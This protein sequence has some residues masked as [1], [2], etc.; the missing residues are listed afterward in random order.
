MIGLLAAATAAAGLAASLPA[1][2]EPLPRE[3]IFARARL[4]GWRVEART[5]VEEV[6]G[7]PTIGGVH[8]E[9]ARSGLKLVTWREGGLTIEIGY[10]GEDPELDIERGDIHRIALDERV[11]EFR[12]LRLHG[13]QDG[14]SNVRY[15]PFP[16][17]CAGM[18][19]HQIIVYGC[20]A[21]VVYAW[22]EGI[23]RRP[24]QPWLGTG[25]LADEL[26]RARVLRIGFRQ[27][28][29]DDGAARPLLWAE[30]P[31]TGLDRAIGWCRSA[32]E[33]EAA[34]RFHGGLEEE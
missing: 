21:D 2:R 33:S 12:H 30:V 4:A 15:P 20:G 32:F 8:C 26:L 6:A 34:R 5:D 1:P 29:R 16:D 24:G 18:S 31:L 22:S 3:V 7:L 10:S 9:I 11:W 27:P 17:P 13:D 23:R 19:S 14:F 28:D 25:L